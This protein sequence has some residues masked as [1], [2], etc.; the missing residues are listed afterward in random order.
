MIP[1]AIAKYREDTE[2]GDISQA[3]V[4]LDIIKCWEMPDRVAKD[5]A[6]GRIEYRIEGDKVVF[7]VEA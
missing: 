3:L 7:E 1:W 6:V 2:S 4:A 5:L